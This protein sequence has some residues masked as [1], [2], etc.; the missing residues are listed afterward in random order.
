MAWSE[1]RDELTQMIRLRQ[2]KPHNRFSCLEDL[3]LEFGQAYHPVP[4]PLAREPKA[5]FQASYQA[6]ARKNSPWIYV[7]G[8]ALSGGFGA[9][10]HAWLTS[11]DTPDAA[12]ETAWDLTVGAE[13]LGIPFQFDYV[14]KVHLASKR[15]YYGV[16]DAWWLDF[17]L[18]RGETLIENVMWKP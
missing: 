11:D 9:M 18:V 15:K 14:R 3:V 8:Y 2:S 12:Y 10:P 7:E 4:S 16:L 17:P 6:A 13:Y 1:L 5:C